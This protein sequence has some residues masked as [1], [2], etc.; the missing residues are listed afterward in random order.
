MEISRT[1]YTDFLT[2]PPPPD[3]LTQ[4]LQTL[5]KSYPSDSF[6]A[7]MRYCAINDK[8]QTVPI[9]APGQPIPPGV[10][11]CYLPRIRCHDCPGKLYTP[12]PDMTVTNFEVHLKNRLHREKVDSRVGFSTV[13]G[14]GGGKSAAAPPP[15]SS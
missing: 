7:L 12:G 8:E 11:F 3:W 1:T 14:T 15:G 2:Q 9:P 13:P 10:Q 4:A 6:E 5:L